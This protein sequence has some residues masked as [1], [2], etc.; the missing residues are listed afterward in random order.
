MPKTINWETTEV[1]F[2]KF[3]CKN[4]D[5]LFSYVGHTICFRH[6]K[7]GHK[8]DCNN[9][10][11]KSHNLPL[12]KYMREHGGFENWDMIVIHTQICKNKRDAERIETE[13][14]EQQ[15]FKLNTNKAFRTEEQ[16]KEYYSQH[17]ANYVKTHHE[18]RL[19]S[20][21]KYNETHRNERLTYATEYRKENRDIINAKARARRALLKAQLN[22]EILDATNP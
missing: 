9:P 18:Q 11:R 13:L 15:Q 17:N 21:L 2:Y 12:Y 5:I 8:T 7:S 14:M 16:R 20:Y 3:V 22:C 6:R 19:K 1:S 10:N 4:P